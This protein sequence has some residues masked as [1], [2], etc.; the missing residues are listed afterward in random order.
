MPPPTTTRSKLSYTS[1]SSGKLK[2]SLLKAFS[3]FPESGG[4][5]FKSVVSSNASILSLKPVISSRNR[6]DSPFFSDTSP[7]SS[8]C[9][10]A[11]PF[12][13]T[14]GISLLLIRILKI[15]GA[16]ASVKGAV[17]FFVLTNSLYFPFAGISMVVDASSTA[18]PMPWAIR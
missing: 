10:E 5:K 15:P 3:S 11:D 4:L 18:F 17:Q 14:K 16:G 7:P 8:Q 2:H 1:G 12:P 9:H 13:K 6:T